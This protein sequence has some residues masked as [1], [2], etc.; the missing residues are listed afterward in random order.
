MSWKVN[1]IW[2]EPQTLSSQS[3]AT[4]QSNFPLSNSGMQVTRNIIIL[5]GEGSL[6]KF[7]VLELYSRPIDSTSQGW[8]PAFEKQASR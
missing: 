7:Q 4:I 5:G 2:P 6:L 3:P 8:E 1:L